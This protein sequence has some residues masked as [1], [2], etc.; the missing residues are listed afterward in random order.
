MITS[1]LERL[2]F[3][4]RPLTLAALLLC[5]LLLLWQASM[6]RIDA[7]FEK[8]LPQHH[9]YMQTFMQYQ[10][11]FGG[12]NRLLVAVSPKSGDIFTKDF[13]ASLKSVTDDVFF[14]PGVD[15]ARVSSLVTPDVRFIEVDEQGFAGGNVIPADFQGTPDD[16]ARVRENTLKSGQV[17]R[18]VANDFTAALVSAQLLER[19]P[20]TGKQLD[21]LQVA[22]KLDELVAK[23]PDVSIHVIGFARLVGDIADGAKGVAMFFAVTAIITLLLLLYYSRSLRF[24][25]ILVATAITAVIWQV[26]IMTA[27]GYGIDPMSILLPFLIFAIAVSHGVQMITAV[28]AEMLVP[29]A[30]PV[31]CAQKAFHRLLGPGTAA[32]LADVVG[33]LTLGLIAIPMI[34]EL[35]IMAALGVGVILVT[36]L[37]L[38]PVWLSFVTMPANAVRQTQHIEHGHEHLWH[39]FSHLTQRKTAVVTLAA[40]LLMGVFCWHYSQNMVIGDTQAGAPELRQ[41]SR[42]NQDAAYIT[43]HF[44][45]GTDILTVIAQAGP[46]ACVEPDV[47][48]YIDAFDW[49]IRNVEGVQSSISLPQAMKIVASGWNEGNLKWRALPLAAG[50]TPE[51]QDRNRS[52]L[53]QASRPIE[54]STG[55]LN[56]DCSIMPVMF[57]LTDHKAET[58]DRVTTAI[59]S[60]IAAH[61]GK[62]VELKLATGNIGV[63]AATNDT[64]REAHW[65]MLLAV[66]GAVALLCLLTFRSLTSVICCLIPLALV[67][68][69]A[70]ALMTYLGIGLKVATLPVAALGVGIGVDYGIYIFS[71]LQGFMRAGMPLA[72][73]YPATLKETGHAVLF[74]GLTLA[75]GVGTWIFSALKFQADMGLMLSFMF[76]FNMLAAIILIPAIA[77]LIIRPSNR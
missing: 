26:G 22:Q 38:L 16:L 13:L 49:H 55:L 41:Q 27:L 66:Y 47:V 36:N 76:V 69:L 56:A 40:A 17:G 33:F 53:T 63:M 48:N 25:L 29:G 15:R 72:Q 3:A 14:I 77:A 59:K 8:Q 71:R 74:T 2:I 70:N 68:V 4:K 42:Y 30:N 57:F 52:L 6:V 23:H 28:S 75:A 11:D 65:P 1:A 20:Q 58:I 39:S 45:I 37:V 12:A 73:A 31:S 35:A 44:S 51:Q 19:D 50:D 9:P 21:Y 34:R 18:L 67:S 32:V 61:P 10:A 62:G 64:V 60:W 43:S 54:T 5:T 7:G 24:S 46:S